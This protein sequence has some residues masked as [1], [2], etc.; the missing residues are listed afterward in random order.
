MKKIL[1][2]VMSLVMLFAFSAASFAAE[3]AAAPAPAKKVEKKHHV[4]KATHHRII[5]VVTAV[6]AAAGTI[7]VKH[8]KAE[9][10]ISVDAK[11][12]VSAGAEKKSIN[13]V[14]AGE[15]VAV[16]Y[17]E[18]N[19]KKV[20]TSVSLLK[21]KKVKKAMKKAEKKAAAPAEEQESSAE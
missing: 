19:G 17:K 4:R 20:A 13:D 8:R 5:G 21:A 6:D 9:I 18:V 15:N 10:A 3:Q 11:T 1:S 14:K 12:R 16:G 7:T 2:V